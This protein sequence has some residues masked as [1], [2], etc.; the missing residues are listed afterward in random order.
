MN[1]TIAQGGIAL[2]I[3]AALVIFFTINTH[4]VKG[5]VY[6]TSCTASS[7]V[8]AVGNQASSRILQSHA[9]RAWAEVAL[10][11][12]QGVATNTIALGL[13]TAAVITQGHEMS[14]TS[15]EFALGLNTDLPYT[16]E[17]NAITSTGS[18]TLR[19]TECRY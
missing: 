6:S 9:R 1:R 15:D 8:V 18:T 14:T 10:P 11:N 2:A 12:T 5:E 7:S 17:V 13:G 16:G 19:V 4:Q 3:I